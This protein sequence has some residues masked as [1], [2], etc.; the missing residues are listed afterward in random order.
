MNLIVQRGK[1]LH[2]AQTVLHEHDQHIL[3][4]CA[5]L[6]RLAEHD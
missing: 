2:K 1:A 3:S 4:P 5:P 6:Y